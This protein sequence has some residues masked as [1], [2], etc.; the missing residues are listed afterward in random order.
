[1]KKVNERKNVNCCLQTLI[2]PDYEFG[3]TIIVIVLTQNKKRQCA[4]PDNCM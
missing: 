2:E 1:M 4:P 3:Y